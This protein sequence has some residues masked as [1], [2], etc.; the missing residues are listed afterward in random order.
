MS[1]RDDEEI[2]KLEAMLAQETDEQE[3][4]GNARVDDEAMPMED[5]AGQNE[6]NVDSNENSQGTGLD[7]GDEAS[8]SAD[9]ADPLAD[10]LAQVS[11]LQDDLARRNADL[12]NLQQEYAAYVKRARNDLQTQREQA[13]ARVVEDILPVLDEIELARQHGDLEAGPFKVIAEKLEQILHNKYQ[14]QRFGAP[15]EVFDPQQHEALA[16]RESADVTEASVEAVVQ[17]GYRLGEKVV[18]P[19]RVMVIN[20]A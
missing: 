20:P 19:A 14:V 8:D 17:P 7:S 12:Y 18:R 11:S 10:A 3:A 1:K 6:E 15:G 13:A 4:E 2:A 16:A 5:K 9:K